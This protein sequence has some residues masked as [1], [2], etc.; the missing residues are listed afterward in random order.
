MKGYVSFLSLSYTQEDCQEGTEDPEGPGDSQ[1]DAHEC[2][3]SHQKMQPV[4][5]VDNNTRLYAV[6]ALGP[7]R[8]AGTAVCGSQ[9]SPEMSPQSGCLARPMGGQKRTPCDQEITPPT[10]QKT[11]MLKHYL[12]QHMGESPQDM[13]FRMRILCFK[14]SAY[15][16]QIHESVLI[17]QNRKHHHLLNSKSEYNRCS[18]TRLTMKIG[19]RDM[20]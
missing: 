20:D 19:D 13:I 18:L 4:P 16:R 17:Q 12:T 10:N 1:E 3:Q 15:E 5:R 9:P 8:K 2:R 6:P 11:G 7:K 14:R